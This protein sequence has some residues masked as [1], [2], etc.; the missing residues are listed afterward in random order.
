MSSADTAFLIPAIGGEAAMP[1]T[2][3]RRGALVVALVTLASAVLATGVIA[4]Q[5]QSVDPPSF[6]EALST[7][8]ITQ[9][10]EV[11]AEDG[12][13]GRGIF[14]QV[15]QTGQLC[16]WEAL[17]ATSGSRGGGCNSIDDPLGG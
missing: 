13:P 7:G 10:A 12:F 3:R 2:N 4:G 5:F 15:T 17:S 8:G 14:A 6:H 1:R 11:Q 16:V 9:I